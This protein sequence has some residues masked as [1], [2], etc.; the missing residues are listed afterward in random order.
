M[1]SCE[2]LSALLG[3]LVHRFP[4]EEYVGQQ[5]RPGHGT[6]VTLSLSL[7][8]KQGGCGLVWNTATNLKGTAGGG[9]WLTTGLVKGSLLKE[10]KKLEERGMISSCTW[11]KI[12]SCLIP[13]SVLFNLRQPN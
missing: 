5:K 7:G 8:A 11:D 3:T 2:S 13:E 9:C 4:T 1:C 10:R 6:S 12:Q